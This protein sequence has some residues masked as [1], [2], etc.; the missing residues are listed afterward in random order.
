MAAIATTVT[1]AMEFY[2][3]KLWLEGVTKGI[4]SM[5]PGIRE[6]GLGRT[7]MYALGLT[8]LILVLR[9]AQDFLFGVIRTWMGGSAKQ[10]TYDE[11][12][13]QQRSNRFGPC[14]LPGD[15]PHDVGEPG[16]YYGSYEDCN[17]AIANRIGVP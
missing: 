6:G 1:R 16:R 5:F 10:E 7:L 13:K 9:A 11:A 4:D 3:D 8:I 17:Y 14:P 2:V 15:L 12:K